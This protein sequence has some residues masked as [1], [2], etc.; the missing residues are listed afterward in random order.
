MTNKSG[1][2]KQ[3]NKTKMF[4]S[5]HLRIERLKRSDCHVDSCYYRQNDQLFTLF[6]HSNYLSIWTIEYDQTINDIDS[7]S[8]TNNDEKN[9]IDIKTSSI[10]VDSP[11]KDDDDDHTHDVAIGHLQGSCLTECLPI[12]IENTSITSI[13]SFQR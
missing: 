10:D 12:E 8:P 6:A 13:E 9:E 7:R 4:T 3:K 5:K 1:K 2:L 11:N